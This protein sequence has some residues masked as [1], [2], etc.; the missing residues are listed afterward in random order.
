MAIDLSGLSVS[1]LEQLISDAKARIDVVKKQQ[2]SE[3]R[4]ALEAQAR[5]A[6]FDIYE[7][8]AAGRTRAAAAGD[9]KLVAPK[10]RNP[11]DTTQ[12]WTGRGKQP[13]WVRDALA[14]GKTL[15]QLAI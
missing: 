8:F 15:E 4:K 13:H 7:L 1:D 11:S 5:S 6:G 2:Y 12:T 14:A 10:Y 3:L 9:K